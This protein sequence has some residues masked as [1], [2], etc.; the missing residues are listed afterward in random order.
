MIPHGPSLS[1]RQI[2]F[3]IPPTLYRHPS[4]LPRLRFIPAQTPDQ[5]GPRKC[6]IPF[7][8]RDGNP[9]YR[10]EFLL[11]ES[12]EDSQ[13]DNLRRARIV[14]LEFFENTLH[15]KDTFKV[16]SA[17]TGFV[18]EGNRHQRIV[19]LQGFLG[20]GMIDEDA[21]ASAWPQPR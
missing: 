3:G 16:G 17:N 10:R 18:R 19:A 6:P 21:T 20:A 12:A 9:Q 8:G 15:G 4:I 13:L 2:D 7:D 1:R 14:R 5:P 11:R